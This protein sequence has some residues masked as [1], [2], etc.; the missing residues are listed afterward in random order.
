MDKKTTPRLP[1]TIRFSIDDKED[2]QVLK[3]SE[4]FMD[5]IYTEAI[6]S[7]EDGIKNGLDNIQLFKVADFNGIVS[8]K[9]TELNTVLDKAIDFYAGKEDYDLC[10]L[11]KNLKQ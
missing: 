6:N 7:I 1:K 9:K 10:Q 3:D 2:F 11:I 8:I 5:T 4:K